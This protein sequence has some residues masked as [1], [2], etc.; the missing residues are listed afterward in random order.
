[1]DTSTEFLLQHL[2]DSRETMDRQSRD[3]ASLRER[4]ARERERV[5]NRLSQIEKAIVS[6]EAKLNQPVT[7][8]FGHL[9]NHVWLKVGFG[10]GM[11]IA[12]LKLPEEA[13]ARLIKLAELFVG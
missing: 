9:W 11:T 5:A 6:L 4:S 2:R 1:M 12:S 10:I 13:A 8:T 7:F 3:L